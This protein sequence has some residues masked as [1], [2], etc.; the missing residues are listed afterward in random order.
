MF[1]VDIQQLQTAK[2]SLLSLC[3]C[4]CEA[5]TFLAL[6][7]QPFPGCLG[8]EVDKG[9]EKNT[10]LLS[11]PFEYSSVVLQRHMSLGQ[12]ITLGLGTGGLMVYPNAEIY[13]YTCNS[14]NFYHTSVHSPA[15]QQSDYIK[16][17]FF[18]CI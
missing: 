6:F 9:S 13:T 4:I 8:G 12:T 3:T 17:T 16:C 7:E 5:S 15:D 2:K 18:F 11:L 14:L 10:E 1:K